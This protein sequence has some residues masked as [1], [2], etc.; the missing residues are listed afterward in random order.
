MYTMLTAH[1]NNWD[2]QVARALL[3]LTA[4]VAKSSIYY[5]S[6]KVCTLIQCHLLIVVTKTT[7]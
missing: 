4:R 7:A 1:N 2:F 5:V 6:T 3:N